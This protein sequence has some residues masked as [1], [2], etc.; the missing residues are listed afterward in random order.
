MLQKCVLQIHF[1]KSITRD[2][3]YKLLFMDYKRTVLLNFFKN[4]LAYVTL[5]Y[6]AHAQ[7]YTLLLHCTESPKHINIYILMLE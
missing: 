6:S 3:I 4:A 7:K 1:T 2:N 5:R